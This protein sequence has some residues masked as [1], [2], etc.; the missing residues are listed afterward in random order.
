VVDYDQ[1]QLVQGK[2]LT[3]FYKGFLRSSSRVYLHWGKNGWQN[4]SPVDEPMIKRTSGLW[5]A[6]IYIP[7]D[8]TQ[9]NLAFHDESGRWDN[10][11]GKNWN[12]AIRAAKSNL[13][14]ETPSGTPLREQ[15]KATP[16][17]A[18]TSSA[19]EQVTSLTAHKRQRMKPILLS[20]SLL[21]LNAIILRWILAWILKT[22]SGITPGDTFMLGTVSSIFIGI[23]MGIIAVLLLKKES[24]DF[25]KGFC[26][27]SGLVALIADVIILLAIGSTL[28]IG[29]AFALGIF[30]PTAWFTPAH[31]YWV[32]RTGKNG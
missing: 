22:A 8:A 16:Q 10:N 27:I 18:S 6:R 15:E 30:T 21:I 25:L 12:L 26:L 20:I 2:A 28:N 17:P 23:I 24:E 5:Q 31:I 13:K 1:N 32:A 11:G 4:V 14:E 7:I 19:P 29:A 3:I 9:I